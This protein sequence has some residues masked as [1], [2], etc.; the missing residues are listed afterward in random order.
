MDIPA[1]HWAESSSLAAQRMWEGGE[2]DKKKKKTGGELQQN[3]QKHRS[4]GPLDGTQ[5]VPLTD[6]L[7]PLMH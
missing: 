7:C 6:F 2:K 4:V 3:S 1:E 5:I